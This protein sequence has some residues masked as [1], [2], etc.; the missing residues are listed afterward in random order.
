MGWEEPIWGAYAVAVVSLPT[1]GLTVNKEVERLAGTVIG[2]SVPLILAGLFFQERLLF[3]LTTAGFLGVCAWQMSFRQHGYAW[4]VAGMVSLTGVTAG[5]AAVVTLM[6]YP[7]TPLAGE[8]QSLGWGISQQN[9]SSGNEL[10][11]DVSPTFEWIRLAQRIPV[12]IHLK[13]VPESIDLRMGTTAS[14]LL[15]KGDKQP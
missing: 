8:V 4:Y 10:L 15:R 11:P 14:V 12:R 6:S 9:G 5:D 3:S 7:D 2:V 1:I 13:D